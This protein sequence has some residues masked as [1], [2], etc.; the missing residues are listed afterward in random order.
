MFA[1][2][3]FVTHFYQ[4][5]F[6]FS[7]LQFCSLL[8]LIVGFLRAWA[9]TS[10]HRRLMTEKQLVIDCNATGKNIRQRTLSTQIHYCYYIMCQTQHP[11]T[12]VLI[13]V[14]WLTYK[15]EKVFEAQVLQRR[16]SHHCNCKPKR[17]PRDSF[18]CPN[19]FFFI[20]FLSLINISLFTGT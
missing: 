7:T 4:F 18:L 1:F 8:A 12:E 19:I 20:F 10:T 15:T 13:L 9:I 16:R 3:I 5:A 6:K 17:S 14:T 11:P 2:L